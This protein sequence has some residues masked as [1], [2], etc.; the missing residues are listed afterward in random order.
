MRSPP[1]S[2]PPQ[3]PGAAR[4]REHRVLVGHAKAVTSVRFSPDGALLAS[5]SADRTIRVW[6]VA[7]GTCALVLL[8]H[9]KG[10]SDV[11]WSACG[12][13]LAS[14]SDDKNLH[15]WRV[16]DD[17]DHHRDANEEDDAIPPSSDPPPPTLPLSSFPPPADL[18]TNP[19]HRR[20]CVRVFSGHTSHVFACDLSR[21][22]SNL[23]ASGSR[24]ET[25]RLWDVRS[26]RC[27][28]VIPAHADPVTSVKF[29]S[30]ATVLMS[31]SYDGVV[32]MWSTATGACLRTFTNHAA[33]EHRPAAHPNDNPAIAAA[34]NDGGD[35]SRGTLLPAA[36]S[37]I[38][39]GPSA[40]VGH[41]SWSLNDRYVLVS[42]LDDRVRLIDAVTGE[43]AKTMRG[44]RNDAFCCFSRV[45]PGS[46]GEGGGGLLLGGGGDDGERRVRT[47]FEPTSNPTR[48]AAALVVSGGD[49]GV[50]TVWDLQTREVLARLGDGVPEA[51]KR[52]KSE[53][54]DAEEA[55][56]ALLGGKEN[57]LR[58][59]DDAKEG[60]DAAGGDEAGAVFSA[61]GSD[62]VGHRDACVGADWTAGT[63]A[64]GGA[65]LATSGLER[66]KTIRLWRA[67]AFV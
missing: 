65:M 48:R 40:P 26:G 18:L 64:G 8:G 23:L 37:T 34:A 66:D 1:A 57:Q 30:D 32:R 44:H 13:Y 20:R 19:R 58:E 2:P 60:G 50:A 39:R 21:P 59:G 22:A 56:G 5:A 45:F 36:S 12:R 42:T 52:A 28:N 4:L 17:E 38:H 11:C 67:D 15:L 31:G 35:S 43:T 9:E 62:H 63:A 6:R 55:E 33:A 51:K 47:D 3:G 53:N 46:G 29:N 54:G 10:C 14:A 7:D 16:D 41:A 25:V 24:D 49:D 61:F 27:V